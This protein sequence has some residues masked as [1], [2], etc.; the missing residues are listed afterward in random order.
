MKG[1]YMLILKRV[2]TLVLSG[3]FV[4]GGAY[5]DSS[6]DSDGLTRNLKVT[7]Y[8]GMVGYG[9]GNLERG[10]YRNVFLIWHLAADLK[11]YTGLKEKH[12]QLS[13]FIE[14]QINPV[15]DPTQNIE[16]GI[17]FGLQYMYPLMNTFSPYVMGSV[18]PHYISAKTDDTGQARGFAFASTIGI[19]LYYF[20]DRQWALNLGYRLRHI[21]N[22]NMNSPNGSI[23]TQ[24]ILM[25][26]S[27]CF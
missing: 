27:L 11:H 25:G 8:G 19:G 5:A 9:Q 21:S 10:Y 24:N 22:A 20:I 4:V 26:L 13:A 14:P 3:M 6:I 2:A 17:G 15:I 12:G 1:L 16:F 18:G 7:E 23:N